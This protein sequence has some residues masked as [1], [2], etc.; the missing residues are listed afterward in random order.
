MQQLSLLQGADPRASWRVR[1]SARARRLSL[2]VYRDGV[3]EIVTPPRVAPQLIESF[4][5]RH[6]EW[7]ERKQRAAQPQRM[8]PFPPPE[9]QLAALGERWSCMVETGGARARVRAVPAGSVGGELRLWQ[10]AGEGAAGLQRVLRGWLAQRALT[11]FEAQL[12]LLARDIGVAV[13]QLQVRWQRSRWGSCSTRGTVS[14]NGALLFQRPEVV[15][16]LM[17]HELSHLRHMN[18]SARFWALVERHEP[19]WRAL[20]RELLG[21]WVHVPSWLHGPGARG[22]GY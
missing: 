15:R 5:A 18:H 13:E 21:G 10:G 1:T 17:V 4:V 22:A 14:L 9:L 19:D 6:R 3:V 16:Y 11:G 20:D 12:A 2:R 7:I 8:D